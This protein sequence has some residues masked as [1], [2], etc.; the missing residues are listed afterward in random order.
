MAKI[1]IFLPSLQCGGAERLHLNLAQDWLQ[2]G[3]EVEIVLMRKEGELLSLLPPEITIV[4]LKISRIRHILFPFVIYLRKSRPDIVLVA[5]W[6]LTS[7]SIISWILSGKIGKIYVSDHN[8]LSVSAIQESHVSKLYLKW[9]IRFTYP[10]ANG[11]I[12]V[13]N[14]V[15]KDLSA[16]DEKKALIR[17][18]YSF[19]N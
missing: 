12:A 18:I 7:Y 8:H 5:M 1:S 14:G 17:N 10:F 2:R 9:F 11:V 3:Y 4:N 13:S 16:K 15:K 19:R 6:P